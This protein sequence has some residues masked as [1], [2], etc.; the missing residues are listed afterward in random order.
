VDFRPTF[1]IQ[2]DTLS[3]IITLATSNLFHNFLSLGSLL[4]FE[5]KYRLKIAASAI[6][7]IKYEAKCRV[8]YFHIAR[9]RRC[10]NDLWNFLVLAYSHTLETR[11]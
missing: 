2:L 4:F 9:A 7:K 8:L 5:I 11:N 10:L 1:L 6:R 3:S